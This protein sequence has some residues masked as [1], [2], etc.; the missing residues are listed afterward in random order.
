VWNDV[1]LLNLATGTLMLA[2][3]VVLAWHGTTWAVR[4]P[5]F[6][7]REVIVQASGEGEL[8]HVNVPALRAI[9]LPDLKGNLFTIDLAQARRSFETVP[10][11]R[12]ASVSRR[13]PD[14]LLVEI[15]EHEPLA[16][17]TD[18]R[19][20]NMQG[21]LFAVNTAEL[22]QFGNLPALGGPDGSEARVTQ[23]Y[24][25][26]MQWFAPIGLAPREVTL[27][28]RY[29]WSVALINVSNAH[30]WPE[31]APR[32]VVVELGR[33]Q[34]PQTLQQ[35]AERLVLSWRQ[36]LARWGAVPQVVD[37]RYPNGFALRI[38]GLKFQAPVAVSAAAPAKH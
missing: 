37:M 6:D 4:Q 15:E 35:R 38:P 26:F 36:V 24:R 16:V 1:R 11:V 14:Q 17:W 7:L 30:V 3:V 23:R 28:G 25:D 18:G 22:E 19:G 5:G 29:A 21:E 20:V 27:S 13:W 8:R 10:W 33:E 12:H 2:L 31:S 34:T 9:A 32:Q